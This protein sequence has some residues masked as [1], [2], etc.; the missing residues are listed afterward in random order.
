MSVARARRKKYKIKRTGNLFYFTSPTLIEIRF[1]LVFRFFSFPSLLFLL[2][3]SRLIA[4]AVKRS[5]F[6]SLTWF[7][8]YTQRK[9]CPTDKWHLQHLFELINLINLVLCFLKF[10]D[11]PAHPIARDIFLTVFRHNHLIWPSLFSLLKWWSLNRHTV[12]ISLSFSP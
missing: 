10:H 3:L 4:A 11:L 8:R 2:W 5:F 9:L 6:L 1:R 7:D 12:N